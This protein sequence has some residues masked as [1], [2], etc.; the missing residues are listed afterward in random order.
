MSAKIISAQSSSV[1]NCRVRD[2]SDSGASIKVSESDTVPARFF[3]VLPRMRVGYDCEVVWVAYAQRGV[4]FLQ[5]YDANVGLPSN[6]EPWK[7]QWLR[8]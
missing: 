4:R 8:D 7:R 1:A 6:M 3:L 5:G 2:I